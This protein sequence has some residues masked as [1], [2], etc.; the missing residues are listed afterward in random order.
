MLLAQAD[1]ERIH[2]TIKAVLDSEDAKTAHSCSFFALMGAG[3]LFAH[4]GIRARPVFGAAFL[5]LD[6]VSRNIL[7]YG[8][9][10]ANIIGSDENNYH[11][12]LDTGDYVIDFMAPLYGDAMRAKGDVVA[13]PHRMLQ[14]QRSAVVTSTA[15]LKQRGD[16]YLLPNPVLSQDM[17]KYYVEERVYRDL[18][19]MAIQWYCKPPAMMAPI[20]SQGSDGT[21]RTLVLGTSVIEGVW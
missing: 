6:G 15:N 17:V 9:V 19:E 14:R 11:A 8:R 5:L 13:V 16:L 4:Y 1:Y 21:L 12:W 2:L 7:S 3:I 20:Q 18:I 10:D